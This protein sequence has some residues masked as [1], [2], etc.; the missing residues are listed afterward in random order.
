MLTAPK[1]E[2]IV[3][4]DDIFVNWHDT[5][6]TPTANHYGFGIFEGLR[7]Y[8]T[9]QGAAI[10]RLQAHTDRLFQSAQILNIPIA[11][12]KTELNNIQSELIKINHLSNAYI[13]PFVFYDGIM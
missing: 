10:F 8:Q 2:H 5:H 9:K 11:Y 4:L 7:A 13:R 3:W 1:D 12:S 6:L